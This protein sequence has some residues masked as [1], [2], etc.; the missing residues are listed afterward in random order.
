MINTET[1][2]ELG[3]QNEQEYKLYVKI[4]GSL[5]EKVPIGIAS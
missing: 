5:S 1:L 2:N 4:M 3:F